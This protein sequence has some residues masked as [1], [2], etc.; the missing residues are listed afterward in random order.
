MS[1]DIDTRR[2]G[3]LFLAGTSL[4][5]AL[6]GCLGDD[7]DG[8]TDD[9]N[10]DVNGVENGDDAG[11]GDSQ[12]DDSDDDDENGLDGPS[13]VVVICDLQPTIVGDELVV[14]YTVQ[15]VGEE[16]GTETLTFSVDGTEQDSREHTL[17]P[18]A[19]GT[20][21][22]TYTAE[23]DGEVT[24]TIASE[25]DESSGTVVIEEAADVVDSF[26][27]ESTGG[28]I[29]VA[30]DTEAE[31][32][33]N[34]L[35]FPPTEGVPDPLVIDAEVYADDTWQA[36]DVD[37]PELDLE[38]V[39]PEEFAAFDVTASLEAPHGFG[40]IYAPDEGEM[41]LEGTLRLDL[42]I[43]GDELNVDVDLEA[44]TGESGGLTGTSAFDADPPT[45][46]LVDNESVIDD[47]TG[48]A[49]IDD[50]LGLPQEDPL[51]MELILEFQ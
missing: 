5:T 11:E 24:V 7:D 30:E 21:E 10:G 36:V 49:L 45:A 15:N 38:G 51:W 4:T 29:A 37:M 31:A 16:T 1:R 20:G 50:F 40:G 12:T 3:V 9:G 18:A 46:T 42:T 8:D 43:D 25:D 47:E 17:D 48:A 39:I 2:R 26:V 28:F 44:T 33:D 34:S 35:G 13:F 41:T 22:F 32:R 19:E 6:A 23:A 14:P 27:A